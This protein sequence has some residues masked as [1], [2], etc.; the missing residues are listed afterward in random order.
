MAQ[1]ILLW[2]VLTV[3]NAYTI[4][5]ALVRRDKWFVAY[6]FFQVPHSLLNFPARCWYNTLSLSPLDICQ[7]TNVFLP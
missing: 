2:Q 7:Y 5:F 1:V 3:V 6:E 4:Q